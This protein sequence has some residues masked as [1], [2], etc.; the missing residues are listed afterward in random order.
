[1]ANALEVET[2]Q[3]ILEADKEPEALPVKSKAVPDTREYKLLAAFGKLN[4]RNQELVLALARKLA[5]SS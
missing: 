3:L 4:Q 1:M 5:K 2:Y